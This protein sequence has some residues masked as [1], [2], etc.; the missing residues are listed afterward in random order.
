MRSCG[1]LH[2]QPLFLIRHIHDETKD[3]IK[4][5]SQNINWYSQ[6]LFFLI[7]SNVICEMYKGK[8]RKLEYNDNAKLLQPKRNVNV[9]FV[10]H[11]LDIVI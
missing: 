2:S 10:Y 8:E 6:W 1:S 7:D 11:S 5:K 4:V 9:T 3:I